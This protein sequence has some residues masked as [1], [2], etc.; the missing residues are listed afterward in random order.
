M[1]NLKNSI[2]RTLSGPGRELAALWPNRMTLDIYRR[3]NKVQLSCD[4]LQTIIR[5][6]AA[7]TPCRFLVFGLGNDSIFWERLNRRGR[8]V[9]IEDNREWLARITAR[10]PRLEA[11]LV[12]YETRLPQWQELL[13]QPHLLTLRLPPAV[14]E[15]VWDVILVDAP[16]G[17]RDND[18]GRM[19]SIH[20]ATRLS[21]G[22]GEVFVHDCNRAVER[23]YCDTY[24][25]AGNL[26]YEVAQ[27]R[28]YR[29]PRQGDDENR[30]T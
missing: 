26:V 2:K 27:L 9:F 6:L 7:H 22:A 21:G 23:L 10:F 4:E 1:T 29:L 28:H 16:S 24:L 18:P 30:R 5:S 15:T 12:D 11:Y 19:R 8:T 25:K 13:D 3:T 14:E 17:W 20:A